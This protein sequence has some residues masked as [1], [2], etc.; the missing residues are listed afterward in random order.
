MKHLGMVGVQDFLS[1]QRILSVIVHGNLQ[2]VF[3]K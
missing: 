1:H 3:Q 2:K